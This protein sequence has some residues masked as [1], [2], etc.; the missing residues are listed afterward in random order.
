M[1]TA[2]DTIEG[3][4]Y[5]CLG[6]S[7][8]HVDESEFV[9]SHDVQG[10]FTDSVANGTSIFANHLTIP[11]HSF[12]SS[13]PSA[14]I[15]FHQNEQVLL[16]EHLFNDFVQVCPERTLPLNRHGRLSGHTPDPTT[17][18]TTL[19]FPVDSNDANIRH[20]LTNYWPHTDSP[21]ADECT[22]SPTPCCPCSL[23]LPSLYPTHSRNKR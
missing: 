9:F 22:A 2:C 16:R 21:T 6:G 3:G 4:R 14:G 1:V 18:V 23:G 13:S 20:L 11:L 5:S 10:L 12:V 8:K 17:K 15:R 7:G 19:D